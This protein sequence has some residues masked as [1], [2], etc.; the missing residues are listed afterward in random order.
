MRQSRIAARHG[1]GTRK[2]RGL[3]GNV[4]RSRA[5]R[6]FLD[7]KILSHLTRNWLCSVNPD[8]GST[9]DS[10]SQDSSV[11][12]GL[13]LRNKFFP[14]FQFL[15]NLLLDFLGRVCSSSPIHHASLLYLFDPDQP[16][17]SLVVA[18]IVGIQTPD[19]SLTEP[20]QNFSCCTSTS[21]S[22][23]Y[24]LCWTN[25]SSSDGRF[26]FPFKD[27]FEILSVFHCLHNVLV[28]ISFPLWHRLEKTWNNCFTIHVRTSFR[29]AS[30]TCNRI[31]I[32]NQ[33]PGAGPLWTWF[34]QS[35]TCACC[36]VLAAAWCSGMSR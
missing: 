34:Q 2:K 19:E 14:F 35:G 17:D 25:F 23:S 31:V 1:S 33:S 8:I 18:V 26:S 30:P 7:R 24:K 20:H 22:D 28:S 16:I 5:A 3:T 6:F 9:S 36:S 15:G 10:Q 12:L 29:D 11:L 27:F 4:G 13:F 32:R 21:A